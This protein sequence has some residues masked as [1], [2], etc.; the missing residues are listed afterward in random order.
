MWHIARLNLLLLKLLLRLL[1]RQRSSNSCN[2][3]P[4]QAQVKNFRRVEFLMKPRF[5]ATGCHLPYGITQCYLPPNTSEHTR[6]NH[7]QT[8]R[9]S[10]YLPRM[11]WKAELTLGDLLRK[12]VVYLQLQAHDCGTA[13]QLVLGKQTSA[14]NYCFSICIIIFQNLYFILSYFIINPLCAGAV[15]SVASCSS[16]TEFYFQLYSTFNL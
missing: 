12:E 16:E 4:H 15:L 3:Q 7:S 14:M 10:I 13:F 5:K 9:Y 6:L 2:I 1:G 11:G 8:G